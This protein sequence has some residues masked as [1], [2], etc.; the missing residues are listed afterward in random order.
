MSQLWELPLHQPRFGRRLPQPTLWYVGN[1][2]IVYPL[3]HSLQRPQL[4]SAKSTTTNNLETQLIVYGPHPIQLLR[5][6]WQVLTLS[7]TQYSMIFS[8]TLAQDL[9]LSFMDPQRL[10]HLSR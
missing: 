6:R 1:P 4:L 2:L 5:Q 9:H 10:F 7:K 8:A 3:N